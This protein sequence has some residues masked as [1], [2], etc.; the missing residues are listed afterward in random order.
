LKDAE[1]FKSKL[2]KL[3]GAGDVGTLLV[4]IVQEKAI[5]EAPSRKMPEAPEQKVVEDVEKHTEVAK[6]EAPAADLPPEGVP[7]RTVQ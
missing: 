5:A 6:Q 2:G 3:D 7:D 4:N 1:L